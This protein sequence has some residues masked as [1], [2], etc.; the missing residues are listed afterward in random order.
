[1]NCTKVPLECAWSTW[2]NW[3]A[4]ALRLPRTPLARFSELNRL[5]LPNSTS[6]MTRTSWTAVR[7]RFF[8]P[9]QIAEQYDYHRCTWNSFALGG[10][11]QQTW[12]ASVVLHAEGRRSHISHVPDSPTLYMP[13]S[14]AADTIAVF[15]VTRHRRLSLTASMSMLENLPPG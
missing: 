10:T 13:L 7:V 14:R 5:Y 12:S 3:P 1:M 8:F 2:W 15:G 6:Y 4:M 11:G 9:S